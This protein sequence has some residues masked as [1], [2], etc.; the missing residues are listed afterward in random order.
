[1]KKRFFFTTVLAGAVLCSVSCKDEANNADEVAKAAI[2]AA[3]ATEDDETLVEA[4]YGR[5]DAA[6]KVI[7]SVNADNAVVKMAELRKIMKE[8]RGYKDS[9]IAMGG[10][11]V[12]KSEVH[13]TQLETL[14]KTSKNNF[15]A[16]VTAMDGLEA[17]DE[18]KEFDALV[19]EFI[20]MINEFNKAS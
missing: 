18:L 19:N 16:A 1:M 4:F 2:A 9:F 12:V 11:I 8:A 15:N 3:S 13:K 10:K 5:V 14:R 17:T 7:A 6:A 20:S